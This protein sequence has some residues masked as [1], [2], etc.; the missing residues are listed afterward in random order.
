MPAGRRIER[1]TVL[2]PLPLPGCP[3]RRSTASGGSSG[4]SHRASREGPPRSPAPAN[5]FRRTG[6]KREK[7]TSPSSGSVVFVVCFFMLGG[8]SRADDADEVGV[9]L[10]VHHVEEP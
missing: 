7:S 6:P 5:A 10:G 9:H 2:L 3:R 4:I 8:L 1:T